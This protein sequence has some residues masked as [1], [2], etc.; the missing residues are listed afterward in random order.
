[1]ARLR[2]TISG[3]HV[4]SSF[5]FSSATVVATVFVWF[6]SLCLNSFLFV[7]FLRGPVLATCPNPNTPGAYVLIFLFRNCPIELFTAIEK[8]TFAKFALFMSNSG[9]E[10]FHPQV[11]H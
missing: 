6:V 2:F 5:L 3:S 8:P 1:M 4:T 7:L 9:G 11:S 10:F